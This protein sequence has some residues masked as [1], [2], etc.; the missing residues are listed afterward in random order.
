MDR[1]TAIDLINRATVATKLGAFGEAI[2]IFESVL[3]S[4]ETAIGPESIRR[5]NIQSAL[6]LA[7]AYS[8]DIDGGRASLL[9]AL[10]LCE[11]AMPTGESTVRENLAEIARIAGEHEDALAYA[12]SSL[13]LRERHGLVGQ[14]KARV[15]TALVAAQLGRFE[16]ARTVLEHLSDRE[17]DVFHGTYWRE[18]TALQLA[19]AAHLCGNSA[20]AERWLAVAEREVAASL[21]GLK[22]PWRSHYLAAWWSREIA[23]AREGRW[24]RAIAPT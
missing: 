12:T 22:E 6:G 8:G 7:R 23:E 11:I 24:P 1:G 19:Q 13:R 17:A 10:G 4:L 21:D 3:R 9:A 14:G 16:E 2:E 18:R 5:A 20:R 15:L